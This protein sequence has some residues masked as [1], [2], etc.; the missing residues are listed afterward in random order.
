MLVVALLLMVARLVDMQVI[1]SG[2]YQAEA[3]NESH[4][5]QLSSLRGGIYD[6]DGA[7]LALSVPTDDVIADDF[8]VTHPLKTARPCRRCW[9][10][11]WRR[12][13]PS[14]SAIPAT[15][16]WPSRSRRATARRSRLTPFPGSRWWTTPSGSSTNGN[17]ASPVIG[18]TNAAGNGAGGIEYA[19]NA[20]LAGT[21]G[22]ETLIE[23]PSGVA[24]PSRR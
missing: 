16:C 15:W 19:D 22:H 17:L 14:S 6:R 23:S 8:Q 4:H 7:P 20:L 11:R 9:T 13:R 24:L 12:W 10:S 3:R 1:H 21:G 2:T 18:F 5:R